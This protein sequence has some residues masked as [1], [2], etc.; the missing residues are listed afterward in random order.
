VQYR[1][2]DISDYEGLISLWLDG[3]G[4]TLRDADSVEG[5]EKY[6]RCNPGLSFLSEE[7][8]NIVGTALSGHDGRRGYNQH[9]AVAANQRES[10]I[11]AAQLSLTKTQTRNLRRKKLDVGQS[12]KMSA[13]ESTVSVIAGYALNV[14]V[15]FLVYPM[16]G[17]EV[18]LESAFVIAFLITTIAFAKNY[19]VRRLF[20]FIHVK[21]F[22]AT[23][24]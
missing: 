7:S 19:G 2:I 12:H 23:R 15:Q 22:G 10:G 24:T 1:I 20:N 17:I 8:G 11:G 3:E 21:T 9:L 6:L 16:F 13:I 5:I 14:I 4:V 18:P